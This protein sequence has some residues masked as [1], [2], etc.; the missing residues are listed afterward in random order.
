MRSPRR[1]GIGDTALSVKDSKPSR[2]KG[3]IRKM[4]L[5]KEKLL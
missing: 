4:K 5:L 3:L 2:K 1:T